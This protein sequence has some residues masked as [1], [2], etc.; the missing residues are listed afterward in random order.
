MACHSTGSSLEAETDGVFREDHRA[1]EVVVAVELRSLVVH[2]W[3]RACQAC[4]ACLYLHLMKVEE[5]MA[6]VVGA[7]IV[8]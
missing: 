1:V 8:L 7:A 6:A 4:Q 2:R 3:G 5:E